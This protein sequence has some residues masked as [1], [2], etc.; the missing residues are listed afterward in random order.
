VVGKADDEA[1]R[2]LEELRFE[3]IGIGPH[4]DGIPTTDAAVRSTTTCASA[5]ARL[6]YGT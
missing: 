1:G 4:A 6:G 3:A 2:R 5:S